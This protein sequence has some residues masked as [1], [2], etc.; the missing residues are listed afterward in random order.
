MPD[1]VVGMKNSTD[2]GQL[3]AELPKDATCYGYC[4][5]CDEVHYLTVGNSRKYAM[6]LMAE[7]ELNK[8]KRSRNPIFL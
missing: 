7:L 4:K 2:I 8:R 5:A 3:I 6:E 1:H